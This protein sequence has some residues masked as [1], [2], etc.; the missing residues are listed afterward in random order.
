M[1]IHLL[2]PVIL[3]MKYIRVQKESLQTYPFIYEILK[4]KI[5]INLSIYLFILLLRDLISEILEFLKVF[6]Q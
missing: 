4:T 2:Y 1:T 5:F 3:K 6:Y